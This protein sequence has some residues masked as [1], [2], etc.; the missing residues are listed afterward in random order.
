MGLIAVPFLMDLRFHLVD[1]FQVRFMIRLNKL[2][3]DNLVY[4]NRAMFH[5]C[6][7]E[8][9]LIVHSLHSH[10]LNQIAFNIERDL[11]EL[12]VFFQDILDELESK[13]GRIR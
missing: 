6:I 11:G 4:I 7:Q 13:G 10:P 1:Q 3:F 8:E 5:P 2:P 12:R 9:S